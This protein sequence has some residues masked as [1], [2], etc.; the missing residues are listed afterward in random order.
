M[1]SSL[2]MS[3]QAKQNLG[4][5]ECISTALMPSGLFKQR[6]GAAERW[7]RLLELH[8]TAPPLHPTNQ[9]SKHQEKRSRVEGK[10]DG[11]IRSR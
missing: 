5:K 9:N 1:N 10:L 2:R 4:Q 3:Y 11:E 7:S 6:A 8:V